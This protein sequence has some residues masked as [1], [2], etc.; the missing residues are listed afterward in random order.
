MTINRPIDKGITSEIVGHTERGAVAYRIDKL[1]IVS[2][3]TE[4]MDCHGRFEAALLSLRSDDRFKVKPVFIKESGEAIYQYSMRVSVAGNADQSLLIQCRPMPNI[5]DAGFARFELSPQ[6]FQADDM[7]AMIKWL[8]A[9]NR[10][11]R[12]IYRIL[13]HAW[14][15]RADFALDFYGYRLDDF[16]MQLK[17]AHKKSGEYRPFK[18]GGDDMGTGLYLGSIRSGLSMLAYEKVAGAQNLREDFQVVPSRGFLRIE[19]KRRPE[20]LAEMLKGINQLEAN[21]DRVV[22]Y[23]RTMQ[24]CERLPQ[25]FIRMLDTYPFQVALGKRLDK[26]AG[27]LP[28]AKDPMRKQIKKDREKLKYEIDRDAKKYKVTM[29]TPDI[30]D[31]ISTRWL[32]IVGQLGLMADPVELERLVKRGKKVKK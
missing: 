6:H 16:Y 15:T 13:Y 25:E 30:L 21:W 22:F 29:V 19:L 31:G 11:G 26:L 17:R 24:F 32:E 9:R 20:K 4:V 3:A 23:S 18:D 27:E 5:K 1:S 8:A 14:I 2:G 10:I 12:R 28:P 7:T